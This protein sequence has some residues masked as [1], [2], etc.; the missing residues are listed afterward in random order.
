MP[1]ELIFFVLVASGVSV[2]RPLAIVGEV[3][4][5]AV[6]LLQFVAA[7]RLVI[8][9]RRDGAGWWAAFRSVGRLLP[10]P[11]RRI[12]GFDTKGLVSLALFVARRR[13]GVP[14]GAVGVSYSGGQLALQLSF[15]FAMVVEAVGVEMLLRGIGAPEGLRMVILVVDLY[16]ILIV[17]AV[18]AAC[19]T[20]PHVLSDGE[21][22]IRYG[23]FFDLRVPRERISS[24]RV[25]RN[26]NESGMVRVEDGRLSVAVASQ[27][28]VV[29]ELHEPVTVVRPMGKRAEA[30]TLRFFAD[31]P[32]LVIPEEART[33]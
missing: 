6:L 4:V 3:A 30:R 33:R 25:A 10:E 15:L 5:C 14:E 31:D 8:A 16:S 12:M 24:M 28:N 18:I 13:N 21:L 2:P 32:K 9:A 17:L 27:T 7:C 11:V 29:V 23:A 26:F 19:V 1:A 22:R 20:R